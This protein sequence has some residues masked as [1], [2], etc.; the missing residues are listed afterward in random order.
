MSAFVEVAVGLPVFKTFHYRVPEGMQAAVQVGV[1]VLVRFRGRRVAG[2]VVG[3]GEEPPEGID[4]KLLDVEDLLDESPLVDAQMLRFYR[5]IASYYLHPLGEVIKTGLPP[6]F[7]LKSEWTVCLTPEGVHRLR[8]GALDP[9]AAEVFAEVE[10]RGAIALGQLVKALPGKATRERLFAWGREGLLCLSS[11]LREEEVRPKRVRVVRFSG[12]DPAGSLTPKRARM[13]AWIRERGEAPHAE[14]A[15]V[16]PSPQSALRFLEEAGLVKVA[17][18]EVLR[19]LSIGSEL[20]SYRR[21][22][23]TPAQAGVLE[24]IV[25]AIRSGRFSP[26]LIHGVTGSGKT[27]VYLRAIEEVLALEKEAIVLVPEISLT[28]QLLARFRERFGENLAL[29]HSGM[30]K[31]ERYDQWRR[32]W[33]GEVKI[34]LGARSAVFAPFR[35]LGILVVDEEHEPTYKQEDKLRYHARDLAVV[36]ARQA[37]AVLLL[38]SATP[39]LESYHNAEQKRFRLLGLPDRVEG[40]ALPAV[41]VVD[42]RKEKV[43]GALSGR[44]SQALQKTLEEGK[45]ALLFLNRRGFSSFILCPDC[46]HTF[47]CPNCSVT[48]THHLRERALRCHYCDYRMPAP[49]DCPCC[50][51]PRLRGVGTGTER[52]EEEIRALLPSA[53]VERMD[54]DTTSGRH[55]HALILKRF[56]TGAIDI[57][58]GTQ[59]VVKG[60]DF[61]NVTLVGVISAD[62]SLHFPDFRAGERTFQLLTQVAGRAGRG[63]FPGEVI[64]QTFNPDHY[65]IQKAREHDFPGFYREEM[66][67]RRALHYPPETRLV[68]LRVT[69]ESEKGTE[70]AAREAARIGA[71][72]LKSPSARGIDLLG[73]SPAPLARLK[74]KFRWH[75]LVRGKSP[76][77]LH[78]FVQDLRTRA[79]EGRKMPGVTLDVD[80]DPIFIL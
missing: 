68:T 41:E 30:G 77:Q 53:R 34:A 22:E 35:N 31:G 48:L 15:K 65:S 45:Q 70:A 64:I 5:W 56:E 27:E 28:P 55:G 54:R 4:Q 46:G 8:S 76:Q 52:L 6:G 2:F 49:G 61:P 39:S 75:M 60:H 13:L 50:G 11:G 78:R 73:P 71:A 23:P 40:R 7:H 12:G 57:L 24:E 36:R 42:L 3:L 29:L 74:G 18:K 38:G 62:T 16:F 21:P 1:R 43:E 26:F 66:V 32:I 44:L 33:R 10:R 63:G 14:L 72:L 19:E 20:L 37:E 51:G 69:G 67:F 58:L 59:M 25:H 80:V 79:E 17:E 47:P 9:V